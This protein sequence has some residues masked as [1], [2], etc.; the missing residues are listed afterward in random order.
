MAVVAAIDGPAGAGKSTVARR[1]ARRLGFT[2]LDTGAMYRATAWLALEGG[3]DAQDE[4]SLIRLAAESLIEFGPL[5]ED[6]KQ[7]LSVNGLDATSA[8]RTPEVSALTSKIAAVPTLR[9]VMVNAQRAISARATVGVV[10]EGR[11]IGTVVFPDAELKVFL[12]ASP[13]ERARRRF[14]ELQRSGIERSFA[15]VLKD[16]IE[17][18]ERD[19]GREAGPLTPAADAVFVDTDGKSIDEVVAEIAELW[20]SRTSLAF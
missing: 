15:D 8:I 10:L 20:A 6:L 19:S 1:L 2:Y 13:E 18:D 11:D 14:V 12:T 9:E 7:S 17:R 4:A 3:I 5:T 16:Q